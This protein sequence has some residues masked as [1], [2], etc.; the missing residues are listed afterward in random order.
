MEQFLDWCEDNIIPFEEW[1][2]TK[3]AR[4]L[5][6]SFAEESKSFDANT[7]T[8]LLVA[9]AKEYASR[10]VR[11]EAE[12]MKI[13]FF[14]GRAVDCLRS[15]GTETWL[16]VVDQIGHGLSIKTLSKYQDLYRFLDAFPRFLRVKISYTALLKNAKKFTKKAKDDRELSVRWKS[17]REP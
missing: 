16:S 8:V 15:K 2:R 5:Q 11:S 13:A 9:K 4:E 14:V 7:P 12:T 17:L 6:I 3:H 10:L 1:R